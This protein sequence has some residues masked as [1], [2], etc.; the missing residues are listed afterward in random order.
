MAIELTAAALQTVA[1]NQ[2]VLFTDAPV[3]SSCNCNIL[4]REGS[5]IVTL[6]GA[7]NQCRALYKVSFG[8]NLSGAAAG[9]FS[10]AIALDGE[11]LATSTA[12]VTLAALGVGNVYTSALISVPRGTSVSVSVENTSAT[13]VD[14]TG[15]N[16]IVERLA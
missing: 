7:T 2:N 10:V 6:K 14:V 1:I 13:A 9:T 12:S 8:A 11:A 3:Y 4:H 5:G 15:A 16:L